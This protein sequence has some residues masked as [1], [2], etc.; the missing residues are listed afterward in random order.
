LIH[1]TPSRAVLITGTST[2]IGAACALDLDRHGFHV[3]AGVRSEGDGRRLQEKSSERLTPILLDVTEEESIQSAAQTIQR[4]MGDRGLAGLVNNAGIAIVGPLELVPLDELR[5][6]LEVNVIG[7]VAVTQAMLPML[8]GAQGR[9]VNIGS[10]SGRIAAPFFGPYAA[11][12]H[13]LEALTDSLRMEL[14]KWNIFVSIVEPGNIDTPIWSKTQG[15]HERFL[16]E[17]NPAAIARYA[18]DIEALRS[19]GQKMGQA[20]LPVEYVV[21][22]VHHAHL[23]RRPQPRY[24]VGGMARLS[25]FL[26]SRLP[27]RLMDR[28]ICRSLGLR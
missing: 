5:R 15:S 12:K 7:Q 21:H 10:V 22:A 23:A 26:K 6:Q 16:A 2:G 13:A 17:L 20:G 1:E 18:E 9:I 25:M 19:A 4:H 3:F 24:P 11:S 28:L 14:R 8:R 27:T